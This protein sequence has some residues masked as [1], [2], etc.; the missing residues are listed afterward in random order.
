MGAEHAKPDA[1]GSEKH[2]QN[3]TNLEEPFQ[4]ESPSPSYPITPANILFL[5]SVIGNQSVQRLLKEQPT[6]GTASLQRYRN[7]KAFNFG[8][9]D[10]ANLKE[11]SFRSAK[12]QPWIEQ[13]F[14]QFDSVIDDSNGLKIPQ[15]TLVAAYYANPAQ[16]PDIS[17]QVTGG[18]RENGWRTDRGSF[19]VHR[20]EGVGYNDAANAGDSSTHEG[21]RLRYTKADSAGD[22]PASMHFAVF[23]N[24]GEAIHMGSLSVSSHGCVHVE[25]G[26]AMQQV[27][28]HSV[29]GRTRVK[30]SYTGDAAKQFFPTSKRRKP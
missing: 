3:N 28:Y 19:K 5:Q 20:I 14:I 18:A 13:I 16:L 26:A 9:N 15:G 1:K 10:T 8:T 29:I 25:D 7:R 21:P 4:F 12:N 6:A 22:R 2:S 11:E 17:I 23:Y 27:N 30:V 24:R